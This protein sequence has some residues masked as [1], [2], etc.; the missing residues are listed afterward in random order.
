[1]AADTSCVPLLEGEPR[2]IDLMSCFGQYGKVVKYNRY[3]FH[4][5]LQKLV[6]YAVG[7]ELKLKNQEQK[8]DGGFKFYRGESLYIPLPTPS[9]KDYK[10]ISIHKSQVFWVAQT[11]HYLRFMEKTA[12]VS[13]LKGNQ[14]DFRKE[15]I[16]QPSLKGEKEIYQ[17][18]DDAVENTNKQNL[19]YLDAQLATVSRDTIVTFD[20]D[21]Y[22]ERIKVI[23]NGPP[24]FEDIKTYKMYEKQYFIDNKKLLISIVEYTSPMILP[25][26]DEKYPRNIII[27]Y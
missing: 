23:A 3:F 8:D 13:F 26:I 11:S 15:T 7:V 24:P 9:L 1:M 2:D 21:T 18:I 20:P 5:K 14:T 10:K 6:S 17:N 12:H 27:K 22:E 16:V 4:P 19:D 25:Y